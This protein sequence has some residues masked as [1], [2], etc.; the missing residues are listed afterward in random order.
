MEICIP[1]AA[2]VAAR[3]H[4]VEQARDCRLHAQREARDL[5]DREAAGLHGPVDS[6]S[7][8]RMLPEAG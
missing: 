7:H 8:P 4:A 5:A 1:G 2:R 6:P 3:L